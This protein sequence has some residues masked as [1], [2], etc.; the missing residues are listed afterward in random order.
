MTYDNFVKDRLPPPELLPEFRFDLPELQYPGRLN[1]AVEL[2]RRATAAAGPE[3]RAYV[4]FDH[5]FTWA[6]VDAHQFAKA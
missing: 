5:E 4:D 1:A 3:G 6:R 2:L